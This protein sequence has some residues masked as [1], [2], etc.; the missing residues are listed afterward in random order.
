MAAG[1]EP[2]LTWGFWSG[3]ESALG[4][5]SPYPDHH[6]RTTPSL[7]PRQGK[8]AE[9][10]SLIGYRSLGFTG[11]TF[12]RK[13]P[14]VHKASASATAPYPETRSPEEPS[15]LSSDEKRQ[16]VQR[17]IDSQAFRRAT[18]MRAFLLYIFEHAN[19]GL[20]E[21]LREQTIGAE[22]LGRKSNYDPAVDNIVRVRA[23]ELRGRLEKYFQSEGI[24]EPVV[25]TIPRGAYVP[26]FVPRPFDEAPAPAIL[27]IT[28]TEIPT[29]KEVRS[30]GSPWLLFAA[31]LL[32]AI[33]ASI[34]LT[35]YVLRDD[36]RAGIV[37]PG[38]AARDFWGQFFDKPNEELKTVYADTSYALWQDLNG[39]DL[40][41]GDYLNRKYLDVQGNKQ[42]NVVMR[43]VTTPADLTLS[44]HLATL[45]AE[46]G[47]TELPQ[48]A[49][50]A[51]SQFFHQG[52]LVLIGSHRS[53]PWVAIY[54]P[55]LNFELG[56]DQHSGAPLFLNRSPRPHEGQV[57]AI[58]AMYDTQK[59]EE[60]TYVS[61]GVVAL[62][63]RCDDHGLTVIVEGLNMQATQAAG[64]LVTDPQR[65]EMLLRSIGH[66]PGTTVAPFEALFQITSLPGGYDS[67]KIVAFR[68]QPAQSCVGG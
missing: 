54:E 25:I 3:I 19:L 29:P 61:F 64:D 43:R 5:T 53:N 46:F 65:L 23:H 12:Y 2:D 32:A 22:V 4:P 40:D 17:V 14:P 7:A 62:L 1:H 63:K 13:I 16:L 67:P 49:R 34:A 59:T 48:F 11:P 28:E 21:R 38:G 50:D 39:K 33:A 36:N 18:A 24:E 26:E 31:I 47:G 44:V 57:F 27:P 52:N 55:S 66:K 41:L 58:P 6:A 51:D 45:A 8:F 9:A 60:K 42:F 10:R 37:R 30:A 68:L 15:V 20:V 56:Q 35:R